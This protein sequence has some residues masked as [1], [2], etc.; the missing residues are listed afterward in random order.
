MREDGKR[1]T[2]DSQKWKKV[3][4]QPRRSY[5][6]V[7]G[8]HQESRYLE[9][10]DI[11]AT[12]R[13]EEGRGPDAEE[14]GQG[15]GRLGWPR[16]GAVGDA[17]ND[18]EDQ[19][20][21]LDGTLEDGTAEGARG[22]D[23]EEGGT[24]IIV[25]DLGAGL[26]VVGEDGEELIYETATQDNTTQHEEQGGTSQPKDAG[27]R[28]KDTGTR[29]KDKGTSTWA[30]RMLASDSSSGS[31]G[32][33]SNN[34]QDP[35]AGRD[36]AEKDETAEGAK[37]SN[38]EEVSHHPEHEAA[39]E[40]EEAGPRQDEEQGANDPPAGQRGQRNEDQ[41]I[42]NP[43]HDIQERLKRTHNVIIG[44][45]YANRPQRA[46]EAIDRYQAGA[47]KETKRLQRGRGRGS[48]GGGG[49]M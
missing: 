29:P 44:G 5:E 8:R 45:T 2:R 26:V 48:R 16:A 12:Y 19:G 4:V 22:S 15:A 10:A 21:G 9:D 37:N 49:E 43:R 13:G 41:D 34:P 35:G 33:S 28:P 38:T 6:D 31:D 20:A 7:E 42:H 3:D 17:G 1:K 11:G 23:T 18:T 47:K 27:T 14:Q 36:D 30:R 39:Q 32:S 40:H 25:E 24:D 46:R